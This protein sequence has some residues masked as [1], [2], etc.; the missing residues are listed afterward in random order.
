MTTMQD[1]KAQFDALKT[2]AANVPLVGLKRE[3]ERHRLS[4]E[5]MER[6]KKEMPTQC[7]FI[8][9]FSFARDLVALY[10][11]IRQHIPSIKMLPTS[12]AVVMRRDGATLHGKAALYYEDCP[13]TIGVIGLDYSGSRP[14]HF[15]SGRIANTKYKNTKTRSDSRFYQMDSGDMSSFAKRVAALCT[16]FSFHVLSYLFFSTLKSESKKAIYETAYA[17]QKLIS[18]VQNPDVLQREVENLINQGVTFMTPEFNE[19]VEKFREAKQVS[20]HEQN[21]SVPAYFI[22]VT[23]RGTQQFVE[24][25]SVQNVRAVEHPVMVDSEP[26]LRLHIDDVPE[27]IMGK[28]SVL[29]ITDV[30]VHVNTVGVRISDTYF[31]VER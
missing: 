10:Q 25:L 31:W 11:H 5:D 26:M 24:V 23:A 6:I 28:L 4:N 27:D 21:R 1:Y 9:G 7:V 22:R 17:T 12:E 13:Y 16:P 18:L 29:M 14:Y 15:M 8:D 2:C 20:V 3:V 19:F 30:G